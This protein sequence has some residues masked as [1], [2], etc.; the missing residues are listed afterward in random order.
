M[1]IGIEAQR[2]FRE[3]KHGMDVVALE[4]IRELQKA[5]KENEYYIFVAPGNDHCL[6]ATAN[7][8]IVEVKCPSYPFWE[9]VGLPLAAR[10]C[11]VDLLH[12]TSNTA[13]LYCHGIPLVLTLHDIIFLEPKTGKNRSAYQNLGRIYRRFIVPRI[14]EKAEKIITVS[15]FEKEHIE[16][17]LGLYSGKIVAIYNGFSRNFK[18]IGNYRDVVSKY[19]RREK[20]IFMLGNSDPKKNVPG[21][22]AAYH[23]YLQRSKVKLPLVVADMS[24][25]LFVSI[26]NDMGI[27]NDDI[28]QY[29]DFTGYIP[30][31]DLPYIYNGAEIFLFA[32]L[33]ESFGLPILESMACGTPVITGNR[34]AL[35]EIAGSGGI[36]VDVTDYDAVAAMMLK[37]ET[38]ADFYNRQVSYGLER[39]KEFSWE[40]TASEYM[41]I[42]KSMLKKE[43]NI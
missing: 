1:K 8:H 11:G 39:V 10:R 4:T 12:C 18:R 2:I 23:R 41:N 21:A 27:N 32:S 7:F 29:V 6:A 22:I 40:N 25:S 5:D 35:P 43:R 17:E 30:N 31:T 42:Y 36:T 38:D 28:M 26:K 37:L 13:P 33:R 20:Y 16:N 15:H 9:Q 14:L 19:I 34:S 3:K 24:P